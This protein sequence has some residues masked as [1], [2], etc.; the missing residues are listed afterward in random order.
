MLA[1]SGVVAP[2]AVCPD[3]AWLDVI[4]GSCVT[5]GCLVALAVSLGGGVSEG[6]SFFGKGRGRV[7]LLEGMERRG[8]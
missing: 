8:I 2:F 6:I 5:L 4:P 7:F 3:L 1:V